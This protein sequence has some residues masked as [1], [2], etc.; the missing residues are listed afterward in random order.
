MFRTY[1]EEIQFY[2]SLFFQ[3]SRGLVRFGGVTGR[4]EAVGVPGGAEEHQRA[5]R[6]A[7]HSQQDPRRVVAGRRRERA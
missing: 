4:E 2:L 3:A 7:R 5:E 6:E 1:V